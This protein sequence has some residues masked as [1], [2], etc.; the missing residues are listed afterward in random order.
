LLQLQDF[1]II[2]EDMV[3]QHKSLIQL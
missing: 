2:L 3:V 1:H